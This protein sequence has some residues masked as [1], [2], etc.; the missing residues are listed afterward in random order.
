MII[1]LIIAGVLAWAVAGYGGYHVC[2]AARRNGSLSP[3]WFCMLFG[4]AALLG[5]LVTHVR[6]VIRLE[7]V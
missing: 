1:I 5:E 6:I 4:P 2:H 3:R 7:D